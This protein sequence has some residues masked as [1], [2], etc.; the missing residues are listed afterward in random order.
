[1][2]ALMLGMGLC[3]ALSAIADEGKLVCRLETNHNTFDTIEVPLSKARAGI[4]LGSAKGTRNSLEIM[5]SV[6]NNA[7]GEAQI[8]LLASNSR[9]EIS[10]SGALEATLSFHSPEDDFSI[11]TTCTLK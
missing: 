6:R 10:A 1:M 5:A 9:M 7:E 3:L 11:D 8:F 4:V 2:K